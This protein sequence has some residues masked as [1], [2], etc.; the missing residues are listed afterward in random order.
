M[1]KR[2]ERKIEKLLAEIETLNVR[3]ALRGEIE[4]AKAALEDILRAG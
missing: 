4:K 2:D 1:T 3:P